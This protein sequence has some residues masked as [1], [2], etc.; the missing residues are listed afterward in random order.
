MPGHLVL[1]WTDIAG[2]KALVVRPHT[3]RLLRALAAGLLALSLA[4]ASTPARAA[5][6]LT[7]GNVSPTSGTTATA[8]TF[9]VH[10]T[11]TDSPVRPAQAVWAEVGGVTVALIKV[12]GS[13]HDGTWQGP[14]ATLPPATLPAG[15]WQVTF[16]ATTS[17]DPQPDPLPGPMVTVTE[18][19]PTPTPA[20]T[21]QPTAAPTP[22]PPAPS[23]PTN[24]PPAP[25]PAPLPTPPPTDDNVP[26]PTQPPSPSPTPSTSGSARP[27]TPAPSPTP[28]AS[29]DDGPAGTPGPF[30]PAADDAGTPLGSRLASLLIIGGSMSLFGAAV[31]ARQWFVSRRFRR[32]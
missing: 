2:Q 31:L 7:D 5:S 4:S 28:T 32:H 17:S 11:S 26:T 1:Q 22:L 21:P 15:T 9:S 6:V 14:P 13:A 24:P 8:F 10:Y 29:D 12:S 23:P 19:P 27:E 16:H 3:A 30:D 20:P 25:V 18:P